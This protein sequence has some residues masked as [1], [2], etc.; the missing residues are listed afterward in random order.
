MSHI[1]KLSRGLKWWK[2]N[3]DLD[4]VLKPV[5]SEDLDKMID[6]NYY[7]DYCKN[8]NKE[9]V[10][11]VLYKLYLLRQASNGVKS[12]LFRDLKKKIDEEDFK[13]TKAPEKLTKSKDK[14]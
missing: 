7:L 4:G 11:L 13:D 14:K 5:I 9:E 1:G 6:V 3:R 10:D 8:K 12:K 2:H